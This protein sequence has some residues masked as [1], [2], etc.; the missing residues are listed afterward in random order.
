MGRA[1]HPLARVLAGETAERS[2][3]LELLIG[4]ELIGSRVMG[5]GEVGVVI[6]VDVPQERLRSSPYGR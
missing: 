3:G 4:V 1:R 2:V 6:R 5:K